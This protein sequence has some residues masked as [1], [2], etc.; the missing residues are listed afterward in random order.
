ML[1]C[2]Q[3]GNLE[4]QTPKLV[5]SICLHCPT[6]QVP[7]LSSDQQEADETNCLSLAARKHALKQAVRKASTMEKAE[8]LLAESDALATINPAKRVSYQ[9][10]DYTAEVQQGEHHRLFVDCSQEALFVLA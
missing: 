6:P 7:F 4:Q 1:F 10:S 9:L 2:L 3:F 5:S 8:Q